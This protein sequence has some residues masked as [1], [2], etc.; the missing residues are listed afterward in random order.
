MIC[1]GLDS[2]SESGRDDGDV[3]DHGNNSTS[4]HAEL[5]ADDQNNDNDGDHID[6]GNGYE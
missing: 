3:E 1:V 2:E 6:G 4:D 5:Y